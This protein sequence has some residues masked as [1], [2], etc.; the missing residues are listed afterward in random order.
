VVSYVHF[1]RSSFNAQEGALEDLKG[2]D[3]LSE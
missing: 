2:A 3:A 1:F